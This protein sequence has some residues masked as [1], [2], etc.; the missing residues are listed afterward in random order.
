MF[1][2]LYYAE[3]SGKYYDDNLPTEEFHS[4]EEAIK[5]YQAKYG[6][7]LMAVVKDQDPKITAVWGAWQEV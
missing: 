2:M 5:H 6:K 1:T 7:L 4:D 3:C